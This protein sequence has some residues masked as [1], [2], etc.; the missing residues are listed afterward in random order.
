MQLGEVLG[1]ETEIIPAI[2]EK[3]TELWLAPGQATRSVTG[4]EIISHLT[5]TGLIAGCV[6]FYELEEIQE[7]GL[8][9][10]RKHFRGKFIVG[11]QV[12]CGGRVPCLYEYD[13][14]V[15]L[16]WRPLDHDWD[17]LHQAL[18]RK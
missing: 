7:K 1:L 10:F 14:E 11:W 18:R 8:G 6:S 9:F 5:D 12:I 13:S 15:F 2:E 16:D 17:E 3:K 4:Q